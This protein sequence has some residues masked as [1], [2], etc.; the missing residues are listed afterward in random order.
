[1]FNTQ[2]PRACACCDAGGVT[3]CTI[4]VDRRAMF[5]TDEETTTIHRKA[6]SSPVTGCGHHCKGEP[7]TRTLMPRELVPAF[8][9]HA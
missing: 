3:W 9:L 8:R 1:M 7:G 6:V 5:G 2:T 4:R